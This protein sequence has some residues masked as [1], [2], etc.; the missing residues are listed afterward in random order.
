MLDEVHLA[1][2]SPCVEQVLPTLDVVLEVFL[3]FLM[4]LVDVSGVSVPWILVHHAACEANVVAVASAGKQQ[5]SSSEM[6][7]LL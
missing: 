2:S 7:D 6:D 5:S 3:P 4:Y 1:F